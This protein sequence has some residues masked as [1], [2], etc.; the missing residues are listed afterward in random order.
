MEEETSFFGGQRAILLN[1]HT[2]SLLFPSLT[3]D[4]SHTTQVSPSFSSK[5]RA[6]A[7]LLHVSLVDCFET[8]IS[9]AQNES[10]NISKHQGNLR[11]L[12]TSNPVQVV[13]LCLGYNLSK[14]ELH[15]RSVVISKRAEVS[16]A[17]SSPYSLLHVDFPCSDN[18]GCFLNVAQFSVL[19]NIS[20]DG[21]HTTSLGHSDVV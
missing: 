14:L 19:Y 5:L 16:P 2:Y 20:K 12:S 17:H 9:S 18:Q 15:P 1:S 8:H 13:Y 10:Y 4:N 6:P 21:G 3:I 7:L 11:C